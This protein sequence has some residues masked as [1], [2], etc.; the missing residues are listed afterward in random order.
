MKRAFNYTDRKK[1]P[2]GAVSVTVSQDI[3][4]GIPT[5]DAN[6][7]GLTALG[8]DPT[9]R[10]FL[11]PYVVST[12]MRFDCGLIGEPKLP[13]DRRLLDLDQGA[14]IRFRVLVVDE[15][16]DPCQ[17]VAAGKVSAGDPDED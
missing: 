9:H 1:I 14:S 11:E 5:F 8:L 15:G 12:S 7:N 13:G 10:I 2:V 16:S 4:G 3:D 17:I 6:L